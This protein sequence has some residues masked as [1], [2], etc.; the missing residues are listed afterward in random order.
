M[1]VWWVQWGAT[2]TDVDYTVG[3]SQGRCLDSQMM[4]CYLQH[5]SPDW[6]TIYRGWQCVQDQVEGQSV[7]GARRGA[8]QDASVSG[9][10]GASTKLT[11]NLKTK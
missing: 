1:A 10:Q 5:M 6:E 9:K 3:V 8:P 7:D 11:V 2:H 4:G